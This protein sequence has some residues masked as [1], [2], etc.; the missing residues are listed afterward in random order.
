MAGASST[1]AAAGERAA[2][3]VADADLDALCRRLAVPAVR[4]TTAQPRAARR[5]ACTQ[6][7]A[8]LRDDV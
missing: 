7:S 3:C 6:T 5:S 4:P 2:R 8:R 1:G